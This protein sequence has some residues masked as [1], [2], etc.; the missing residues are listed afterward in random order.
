[1]VTVQRCAHCGWEACPG[2]C[3][4]SECINCGGIQ[5]NFIVYT[6]KSQVKKD[7]FPENGGPE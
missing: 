2:E 7:N 6:G 5:F 1:M 3:E 4:Y